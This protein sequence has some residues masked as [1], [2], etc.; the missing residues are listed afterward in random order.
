MVPGNFGFSSVV[1]AAITILAPS[2]AHFL[3]IAKPIPL[4]A[5]VIN[6]TLSNFKKNLLSFQFC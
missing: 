2:F 6:I 1:F 4:D 3:A 5:P